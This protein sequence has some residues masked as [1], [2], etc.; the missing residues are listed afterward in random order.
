MMELIQDDIVNSR[1][2]EEAKKTIE[3]YQNNGNQLFKV[4]K[5]AFHISIL[6]PL[7]TITYSF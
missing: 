1:K 4:N 6:H 2:T 7:E 3:T 5:T